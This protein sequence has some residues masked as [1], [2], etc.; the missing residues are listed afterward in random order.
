[1][2]SSQDF[3]PGKRDK[4]PSTKREWS[5]STYSDSIESLRRVRR[6]L[7]SDTPSPDMTG[8]YRTSKPEK[9]PSTP[10]PKRKYAHKLNQILPVPVLHS[11]MD[12]F[13]MTFFGDDEWGDS[14]YKQSPFDDEFFN[15]SPKKSYLPLLFLNDFFRSE[16]NMR[17]EKQNKS[18]TSNKKLQDATDI[19]LI[20]KK[21]L[22]ANERG[23]DGKIL[24]SFEILNYCNYLFDAE[25]F[26]R[27]SPK[28]QLTLEI[29]NNYKASAQTYVWVNADQ[30]LLQPIDNTFLGY[31]RKDEY[32]INFDGIL[33]SNNV[34]SVTKWVEGLKNREDS[35]VVPF[36]DQDIFDEDLYPGI[37]E[38]RFSACNYECF[39][40]KC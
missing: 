19:S 12:V 21:N 11:I 26:Y 1:M 23:F 5:S 2:M 9:L 17:A 32:N 14:A 4:E 27:K 37:Y 18:T 8:Q 6:K 33:D 30:T 13:W 40:E 38:R 7:F 39:A 15:S 31:E 36:K 10:F 20:Q 22:L 28:S 25:R 3:L 34:A 24:A 16:S 35:P 29:E